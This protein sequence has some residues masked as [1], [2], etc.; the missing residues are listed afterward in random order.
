M[1]PRHH[2]ITARPLQWQPLVTPRQWAILADALRDHQEPRRPAGRPDAA[3]ARRPKGAGGQHHSSSRSWC[4]PD[5]CRLERPGDHRTRSQVVLG[6]GTRAAARSRRR[7]ARRSRE[8]DR[9]PVVGP[10]RV[11]VG[12]WWSL[13]TV[14]AFADGLPSRRPEGRAA[15]VRPRC[16]RGGG[17]QAVDAVQAAANAAGERY[18]R[19]ECGCSAFYADVRVMPTSGRDRASG[20]VIG[21]SRSA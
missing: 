1:D 16:D 18:P 17:G 4:A 19:A 10:P 12:G 15:G 14:G 8:T 5:A 3:L 6:G 2:S 13:G 21:A 9:T 20:A 7:C 11:R